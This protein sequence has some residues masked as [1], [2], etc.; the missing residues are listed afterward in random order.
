[1]S[2]LGMAKLGD[3]SLLG[4]MN[5]DPPVPIL[6]VAWTKDTY[7]YWIFTGAAEGPVTSFFSDAGRSYYLSSGATSLEDEDTGKIDV[8]ILDLDDK[9]LWS[10]KNSPIYPNVVAGKRFRLR[11]RKGTTIYWIAI[12]TITDIVNYRDDMGRR[13]VR[14][15]GQNDWKLLRDTKRSVTTTLMGSPYANDVINQ[16]LSTIVWPNAADLGQGADMY[17]YWWGDGSSAASLIMELVH[18]E[19]GYCYIKADGTLVYRNR[20]YMPPETLYVKSEN[21]NVDTLV[22]SKPTDNVRNHLSVVTHPFYTVVGASLYSLT[23][24]IL[25]DA[26]WGDY[27]SAEVW[28]D[29]T[30]NGQKVTADNIIQT[31]SANT[32]ADGSGTDKTGLVN[33]MISV[34]GTRFKAEITNTSDV[35]VYVNFAISGDALAQGSPITFQKVD[36]NS[37]YEQ[38]EFTLDSRWMTSLNLA[39]Q[40]LLDLFGYLRVPQLVHT[41][42]ITPDDPDLMLQMDLGK[43][44][45][46]DALE[47]GIYGAYRVIRVT[48]NY[49]AGSAPILTTKVSVEPMDAEVVGGGGGGDDFTTGTTAIPVVLPF[50]VGGTN[51]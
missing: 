48:H 2:T 15:E 37:L 14:M 31:S 51:A 32:Q 10:N 45:G 35:G 44:M 29:L 38:A 3:G 40:I 25:L 41:F 19:L 49:D 12:G 1:M 17:Q 16:I 42:E 6:E 22:S 11:M 27:P 28:G 33:V 24:P 21:I 9:Y 30:Y 43:R 23:A 26:N 50:I 36:N 8:T 20:Y 7:H 46:I 39:R 13:F 18:T 47:N 5:V 34:F 4:V